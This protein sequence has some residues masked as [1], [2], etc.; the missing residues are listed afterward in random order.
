MNYLAFLTRKFLDSYRDSN[1][2]VKFY[3]LKSLNGRF[4]WVRIFFIKFF[5]SFPKLR[6]LKKFFH[7]A[8]DAEETS[9]VDEKIKVKNLLQDIDLQGYSSLFHIKDS[10]INKLKNLIFESK[11]HDLQK[12]PELY[13]KKNF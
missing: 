2:V 8:D 3:N 1:K 13:K 9:F 5:Y 7:L 6:N 11:K 12:I 10:Y 4:V